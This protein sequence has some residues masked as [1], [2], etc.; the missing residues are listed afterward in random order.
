MQ[1]SALDAN[2]DGQGTLTRYWAY[3]YFSATAGGQRTP[4]AIAAIAHAHA[5]LASHV[6]DCHFVYNTG[7][8]RNS[9]LAVRLT[10]TRGGERVFLYHEIHVNNIP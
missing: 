4:A 3:G 2:G 8:Q 7:N 1:G 10:I 5:I 6:S 9:L